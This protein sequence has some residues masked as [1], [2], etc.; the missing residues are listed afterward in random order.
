M[1]PITCSVCAIQN[2][3][4]LLN[5]IP[6]GVLHNYMM[7]F[8]IQYRLQIK[9]LRTLLTLEIR[10]N[11]TCRQDQFSQA[12]TGQCQTNIL[13]GLTF[14]QTF[15]KIVIV[16]EIAGELVQISEDHD[17]RKMSYHGQLQD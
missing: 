1:A 13:F 11:F 6:H 2:L 3:L 5:L 7:T 9:L 8:S 12:Q 15:Q 17:V 16:F 4:V 14:C 10:S